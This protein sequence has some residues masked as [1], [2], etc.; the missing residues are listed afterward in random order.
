MPVDTHRSRVDLTPAL[1]FD[2]ENVLSVRV[3]STE[4]RQVPPEG[5]EKMF[6]YYLFGG[7]QREVTLARFGPAAHQRC[8]LHHPASTAHCKAGN[9]D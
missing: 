7:I 8:V 1:N 2:A 3:D 6:G 9:A 4:Q 5:A